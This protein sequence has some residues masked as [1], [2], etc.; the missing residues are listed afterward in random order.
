MRIKEQKTYVCGEP[1]EAIPE[2]TSQDA[3]SE[4]TSKDDSQLIIR[5][6]LLCTSEVETIYYSGAARVFLPP[7]CIHCGVTEDLLGDYDDYIQ[8]MHEK[9]STVRPICVAC[10]SK[11][12][13]AKTWG[14]KFFSKKQKK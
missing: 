4:D 6:S 1:L 10:R 11:G 12:L 14:Q 7:C 8:A 5:R 2:G 13:E 9:F 3:S